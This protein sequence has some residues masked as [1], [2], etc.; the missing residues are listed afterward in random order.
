ME[1]IQSKMRELFGHSCYGYCI[2]YLSGKTGIKDLTKAVLEGWY[3]GYIDDDGYV[4]K[5]QLFYNYCFGKDLVKDVEK[6][7][8]KPEPFN[9]IV[10]FEY[11]GGT[12]FVVMRDDKVVFDPY[13]DSNS[14][15]YG[16]ATTV[17]KF[18]K[19]D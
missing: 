15:K 11:N 19:K 12:H 1:N 16:K 18:I 7:V 10:C 9:Q 6:P 13:G 4:S 5:P 2:A 8:Y 14:V 3:K 17:R